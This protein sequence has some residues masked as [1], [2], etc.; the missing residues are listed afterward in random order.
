MNSC[1]FRTL[2]DYVSIFSFGSE[3]IVLKNAFGSI[4]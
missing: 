1:Y 2:S 3:M 4:L